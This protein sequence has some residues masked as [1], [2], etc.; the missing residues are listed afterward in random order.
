MGYGFEPSAN[1]LLSAF[2]NP[3]GSETEYADSHQCDGF[4]KYAH[5]RFWHVEDWD[6]EHASW[7]SMERTL[8]M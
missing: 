2:L 6:R 3:D 4:A 1:E 5:D 7:L 8:V